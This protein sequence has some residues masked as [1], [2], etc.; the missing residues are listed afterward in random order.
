M[1]QVFTTL[2]TFGASPVP[3]AFTDVNGNPITRAQRLYVE[4]A[5]GNLHNCYVEALGTIA[6]A[7]GATAGVLRSLAVPP[8]ANTGGGIVAGS[9]LTPTGATNASPSNITVAS[10]TGLAAGNIIIQWGFATNL[11][12]NGIFYIGSIVNSTKYTLV[13]FADGVTP[14]NGTGASTAGHAMVLTASANFVDR[15]DLVTQ[16]ANGIDLKQFQFDGFLGESCR[17]SVFV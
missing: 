6:G 17:V 14:I 12:V 10:T 1:L 8:P 16:G 9:D 4:P 15:F 13:S 11:A 7:S 3:L 2:L 5:G